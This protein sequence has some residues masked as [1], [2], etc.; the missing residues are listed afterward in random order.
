VREWAPN[1][2]LL[3]NVGVVQARESDTASLQR[4]LH[5]VGANALCVHMN[6]A[7]ELIQSSGDRDFRDGTSTFARLV[8]ELDVPVVAKETGNGVSPATVQ[9]LFDAGVRHVDVSGAGGTSWVGVE[10]LR[11]TGTARALGEQLWDWGIPT[12][13]SVCFAVPHMTVI[14][15]GGIKTGLDV[16]RS[17]ALGATAAGI[18]RPAFQAF[19]DG[20][21]TAVDAFFDS[22]ESSLRA[23]MLLVGAR[24]IGELQKAPRVITGELRDWLTAL[25]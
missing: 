16:A 15:T 9:K 12:A 23:V 2:L 7:M 22:I 17:I 14:A 25:P 1:V 3:G 20:G 10:T 24:T 5:D 11:T 6:P 19:V 18:A 13:A 4:M 21:R 8:D